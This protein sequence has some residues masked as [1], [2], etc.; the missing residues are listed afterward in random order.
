M[1]PPDVTFSEDW[2]R[3]ELNPSPPMRMERHSE[4]PMQSESPLLTVQTWESTRPAGLQASP[5]ITSTTPDRGL[6][7]R[8]AVPPHMA[9]SNVGQVS[10]TEGRGREVINDSTSPLHLSTDARQVFRAEGRDHDV[11]TRRAH[12]DDNILVPLHSS[13][14][15][16]HGLYAT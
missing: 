12:S 4:P 7:R 3:L 16:R 9:P 15:I 13:T 14:N 1:D 6:R 5:G 10:R 2:G 11:I 8:R